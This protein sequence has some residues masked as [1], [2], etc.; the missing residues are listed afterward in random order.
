MI[1]PAEEW[2]AG[3]GDEGVRGTRPAP[4][5]A[6]LVFVAGLCVVAFVAARATASYQAPLRVPAGSAIDYYIAKGADGPDGA[7]PTGFRPSDLDLARWAFDAWQRSA[8][9]GLRFE[10]A[11]ESGALVRLYWAG[12]NSGEYGETRPL[13][14]GE[15]RGAAVFIRPD[16]ESLGADIAE[17]AGA[18]PLLRDSIVYLTCVHE[19]GHALGLEHTDDFRDIMYFF[20]YGG[21]IVE[22][23]S[24]Y[25]RQ[26]RSRDDIAKVSGLSDG[27]LRRLR[28]LY[29]QG[30]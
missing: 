14:L 28:A 17:R 24:R 15:R 12:P 18:D 25:R 20:G 22:Y 3:A 7:K 1:A 5:L 30:P 11:I 29:A 4:G 27:D 26:L 21:D 13:M 6:A 19:L 2:R 8:A 16:M 9:S 23:F 10:P